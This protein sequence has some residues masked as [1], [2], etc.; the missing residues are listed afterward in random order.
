[1]NKEIEPR[2]KTINDYLSLDDN[3]ISFE[4][5]EYQRPYSW[6]IEQCDKLW[7]DILDR[8][9]KP[10]E[11]NHFFGTIILDCEKS[12]YSLIDG[13]QRTTSFLLLSKALLMVINN[14][15][16][17][18]D[19]NSKSSK[20]LYQIFKHH[21]EEL[22]KILYHVKIGQFEEE[23]DEKK[24]KKI[25]SKVKLIKN[26]SLRDQDS[27]DFINI[28]K[29]SSIE[30][31]NPNTIK[32]DTARHNDNKYTNYFN[33]FKFFYY[34]ANE[35]K[36]SQLDAFTETFLKKCEV[37]RI[38]SWKFDQAINMFN[39]LNGDGMPLNDADIIY[40]QM[41]S[42]ANKSKKHND[43]NDKWNEFQSI[44]TTLEKKKIV[45][46]DSILMQQMYYERAKDGQ[47]KTTT[48]GL[49]KYFKDIN[50]SFI[51][52]P[53]ESC[54]NII[55]LAN[56]WDVIK[57]YPITQ[58]MFK[59]NEN[60]KLFLAS[61][62]YRFSSKKIKESD[63]EPILNCLLRLFAIMEVVDLG[64]S[65]K[66]FKG[67]LFEE[68]SKLV[69]KNISVSEI[70]RDF[71][72]HINENWNKKGITADIKKYTK[73]SL[74]FLNEYL[75]AKNNK[76]K[77]FNLK[78]EY[79][80]EHIMP[81]SGRNLDSIRKDANI[82]DNKEFSEYVDKIGNKI[83]LE[84]NINRSLGRDWFEQK[85]STSIKNKKGYKDSNYPLANKLVKQY[86]NIKHPNWTKENIDTATTEAT[87][88]IIKYIFDN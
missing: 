24:D 12:N 19:K 81:N 57:E 20:T 62:L 87:E 40:S 6:T 28:M 4:I 58:V 85:I 83:L 69:D 38:K 2:L 26:K 82:R 25:Y 5:P 49:R 52:N 46:I 88:R 60:F 37:I 22:M 70:K 14:A 41:Y 51:K 36:E 47:N 35:L 23:P 7:Q 73:N 56:I 30:E 18:V 67:F 59:F 78:G 8:V 63:V 53:V 1:M 10:K 3:D 31:A 66:Q 75:Y 71:D 76:I 64:Y 9:E 77:N 55:N 39:S 21:R 17:E 48:P 27:I 74:V 15:I 68:Q 11:D 80:I 65:S 84:Y 54:N 32:M 45:T 29:L 42:N 43:F 50:T 34:K 13:Q 61:Y 44:I 86:K 72:N 33:N 79:D 16:I